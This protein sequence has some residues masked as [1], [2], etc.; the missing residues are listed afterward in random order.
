[1]KT[2]EEL[3]AEF[4]D[5]FQKMLQGGNWV[6]SLPLGAAAA[7]EGDRVLLMCY[8]MGVMPQRAWPRPPWKVRW[9]VPKSSLDFNGTPVRLGF[10]EQLLRRSLRRRRQ[11]GSFTDLRGRRHLLVS[12]RPLLWDPPLRWAEVE[13]RMDAL[14]VHLSVSLKLQIAWQMYSR[15]NF[16]ALE[17]LTT[18]RPSPALDRVQ[19]LALMSLRTNRGAGL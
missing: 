10:M 4:A 13:S 2:T 6:R 18:T 7:I 3:K 5:E 19:N 8:L 1:M 14:A 17:E 9:G 16:I 11:S 15:T 12:R